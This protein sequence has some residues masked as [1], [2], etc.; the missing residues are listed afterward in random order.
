MWFDII[1]IWYG[2]LPSVLKY[3][4]LIKIQLNEYSEVIETKQKN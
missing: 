4:E 3:N 2:I 1:P